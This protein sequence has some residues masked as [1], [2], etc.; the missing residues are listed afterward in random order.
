[1]SVGIWAEQ[2]DLQPL[3]AL[4]RTWNMGENVNGGVKA[5]HRGGAKPGQF[6]PWT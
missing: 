6:A 4:E 2:N 3:C 1:L 5:G